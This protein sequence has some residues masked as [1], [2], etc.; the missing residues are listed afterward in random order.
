MFFCQPAINCEGNSIEILPHS[1]LWAVSMQLDLTTL[2][3]RTL[4]ILRFWKMCAESEHPPLPIQKTDWLSSTPTPTQ[5]PAQSAHRK[6]IHREDDVLC[7]R[8]PLSFEWNKTHL[9]KALGAKDCKYRKVIGCARQH[10]SQC[11]VSVG[12]V[13]ASCRNTDA[14]KTP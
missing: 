9:L 1:S 8:T 10:C 4:L 12:G 11:S 14:T 13:M 6:F 5:T 7:I 3:Y 2:Y